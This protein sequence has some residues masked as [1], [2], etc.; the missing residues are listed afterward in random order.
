MGLNVSFEEAEAHIK[1]AER[2]L[3]SSVFL[4]EKGRY[5][6]AASRAYYSVFHAAKAALASVE[7]QPKTYEG[8]VRIFGERFMKTEVF[9]AEMGKTLV[10]AKGLREKADYEPTI[11]V[12][13]EH[14]E[15]IIEKTTNFLNV[16]KE[17]LRE[18]GGA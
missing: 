12:Q 17:H 5:E 18:I 11:V 1:R 3:K 15:D 7:E 4:L 6:D 14:V 16:I 10:L 13:K 9:P 8:V 2:S